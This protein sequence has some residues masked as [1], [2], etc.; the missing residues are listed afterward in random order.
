VSLLGVVTLKE[1]YKTLFRPGLMNSISPVEDMKGLQV[2]QHRIYECPT[3]N[4]WRAYSN[5]SFVRLVRSGNVPLIKVL[6]T[7][8][9]SPGRPLVSYSLVS[10]HQDIASKKTK[11]KVGMHDL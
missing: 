2:Q 1:G 7:N 3:V 8:L 11:L 4:R 9:Q 6:S 10:W 5:S